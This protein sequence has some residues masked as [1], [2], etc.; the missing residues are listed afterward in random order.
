VYDSI[1]TNERAAVEA[2]RPSI[3]DLQSMQ[4]NAI[5]ELDEVIHVLCSRIDPVR[6][7]RETKVPTMAGDT[8]ANA[9]TS[10]VGAEIISQVSRL[11]DITRYVRGVLSEIEC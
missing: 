7:R 2:A 1:S 6:V 10:P 3:G 5:S 4:S 8:L 11:Q 9:E